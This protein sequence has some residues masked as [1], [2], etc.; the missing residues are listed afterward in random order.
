LILKS[1]KFAKNG[2]WSWRIFAT[3]CI[4]IT[5]TR[6]KWRVLKKNWGHSRINCRDLYKTLD[7]KWFDS[8]T[9]PFGLSSTP[10]LVVRQTHHLEEFEGRDFQLSPSPQGGHVMM[11]HARLWRAKNLDF[12]TY[13]KMSR[14]AEFAQSLSRTGYGKSRRERAS[15]DPRLNPRG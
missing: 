2:G 5:K 8:S 14:D 9:L 15:M 3:Y 10:P 4:T 7:S 6:R 13:L 1:S 11:S 12:V